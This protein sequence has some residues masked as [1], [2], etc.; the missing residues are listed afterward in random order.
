MALAVIGVLLAVARE[1]LR[2]LFPKNA[3]TVG[4]L[5]DLALSFYVGWLLCLI[6]SLPYRAFEER[7]TRE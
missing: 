3:K 1:E 5:A 2:H 7:R 6:Q 4:G